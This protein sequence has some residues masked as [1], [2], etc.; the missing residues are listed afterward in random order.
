MSPP[1]PW[2]TKVP[3]KL[4]VSPNSL[5]S[6]FSWNYSQV[7]ADAWGK[8]NKAAEWRQE[9]QARREVEKKTQKSEEN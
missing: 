6:E 2:E 3:R 9:L 8:R 4:P 1:L 5:Q 7:G